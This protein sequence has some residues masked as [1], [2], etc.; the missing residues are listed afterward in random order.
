MPAALESKLYWDREHGF[1]VT[2]S[3][4]LPQVPWSDIHKLSGIIT[5]REEAGWMDR[6]KDGSIVV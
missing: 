5:W 3:Q 2:M 4:S 6:Q 1:L